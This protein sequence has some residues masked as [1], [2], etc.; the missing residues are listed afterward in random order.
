[1][2]YEGVGRG[3]GTWKIPQGGTRRGSIESLSLACMMG[4]FFRLMFS[5]FYLAPHNTLGKAAF[6]RG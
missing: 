2:R 6:S 1:M 3:E 4:F 5:C